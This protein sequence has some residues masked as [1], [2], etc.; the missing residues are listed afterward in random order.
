M[1]TWNVHLR[2]RVWVCIHIRVALNLLSDDVCVVLRFVSIKKGTQIM[3]KILLGTTGLVGA[4][5][6]ATAAS[7]ETPKVTLGGFSDFQAG[8]INDDNDMS[9]NKTA[10]RND[11]TIVVKVDGKTASGMGYGAQID[12][13]ADISDDQNNQGANASRTFTYL[14]GGFGRVEMGG[15]KSVA[16]TQ[17]IDASTIAV[18]TGGINGSWSQFLTNGSNSFAGAAPFGS[19]FVTNSKLASEHGSY[20]YAGDESTYNATK[21]SYYTPKFAG[22]QAGVSYTPNTLNRGQTATGSNSSATGLQDVV[23]LGLTYENT[24]SGGYKLGLSGTYE[25]ATTGT[26]GSTN[27]EVNGWNVGGM[28]GFQGFSLAASYGKQGDTGTALGDEADYWTA[29]LG[30]AAGPIGLSA[31]YI[32][33]TFDTAAAA[34][35]NEFNNLVLGADYKLAPG[36]TPYAEVSF[37]DFSSPTAGVTSNNEGTM[38]LVGTQVAF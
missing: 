19:S 27:D 21:V 20:T 22:F 32:D 11:N 30:Y 13:E 36:L 37:Y 18:A 8:M 25:T 15:N 38:V 17:R 12:L 10:F 16:A 5:L 28:L 31:T 4:A 1:D 29:G 7:A 34:A 3:K 24:F 2:L 9:R 33:S 26:A 14:E 6:L 23:D 35:D